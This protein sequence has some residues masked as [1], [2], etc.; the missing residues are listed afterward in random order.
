MQRQCGTLA[1]D[2]RG[3][4][5]R[6]LLVRHLVLPG[7]VD[8]TRRVLD[9]L[10]EHLPLDTA[11]SLMGQYVPAGDA[12]PPPLQRRLTRNEYRRAREYCLGKGFTRVYV[13]S[14]AAADSAFTPEFDGYCE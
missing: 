9:F 13:Q 6:G 2:D 10:A 8:E 7:S 3:M 11:L 4:A 14:L 12:L 1:L 5:K